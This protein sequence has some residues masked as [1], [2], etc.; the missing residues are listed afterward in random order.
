MYK[1]ILMTFLVGLVVTLINL[2]LNQY[3]YKNTSRITLKNNSSEFY[4]FFYTEFDECKHTEVLATVRRLAVT[5]L[6]LYRH[7][8]AILLLC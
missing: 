4:T 6:Q 8:P 1:F 2:Y 3:V 7:F 5:L